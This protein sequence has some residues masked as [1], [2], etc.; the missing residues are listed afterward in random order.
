[1]CE[2]EKCVWRRERRGIEMR[3][4]EREMVKN[5]ELGGEMRDSER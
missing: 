5:R 3:D 4:R 2:R 1:V